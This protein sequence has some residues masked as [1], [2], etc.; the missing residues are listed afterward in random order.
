MTSP[1][2]L[3][4][5][6]TAEAYAL[7]GVP[8][9]LVQRAPQITSQLGLIARTL[10]NKNLP[11]DPIYYLRA[12]GLSDAEKVIDAYFSVSKLHAR[13]LPIEAFCIKAG[14]SPLRVI[15]IIIITAMRMGT[16]A[17]AF[18]A[19]VTSPS[20]VQAT[21]EDA[22]NGSDKVRIAAQSMLHKATGFLPTPKGNQT[23]IVVTQN[24][25]PTAQ[26]ANVSAPPPESTIRRLVDRFNDGS[27]ALPEHDSTPLSLPTDIEVT[28][29]VLT[30]ESR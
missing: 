7:L 5:D 1:K 30:E 14:V 9:S 28:A 12:S 29:D 8:E 11:T 13:L 4:Q 23:S 26:V 3:T 17:S 19:H 25:S 6:R 20:I 21:I 15:E 10:Q 18:L 2:E 27:K 24:A 22:L 16:Q